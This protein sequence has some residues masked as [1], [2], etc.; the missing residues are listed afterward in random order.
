MRLFICIGYGLVQRHVRF[1][2]FTASNPTIKNGGFLLE[3]K[4][5]IYDLIPQE[6]YPATLF[7]KAGS[8]SAA[9]LQGILA[10]EF[11]FPLIG[12]P[13]IGGRGRGAK[14]LE[15][16]E[17]VIEYVENSQVDFFNSGICAI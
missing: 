8:G 16:I 15:T 7:F 13:D 3:S 17:D 14:K 2:F 4:K 1:F 10:H 9:I 11:S 5:A 6:Y 12:K